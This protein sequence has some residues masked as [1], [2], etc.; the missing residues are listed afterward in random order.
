MVR[1]PE[2]YSCD[3]N[4][5]CFASNSID[6]VIS[7]EIKDHGCTGKV[8]VY[9]FAVK[10]GAPCGTVEIIE[11]Q[12]VDLAKWEAR[13]REKER[14]DLERLRRLESRLIEWT[15]LFGR[16]LCPP[17]ADTYGEGIMD[18]KA[19]VLSMIIHEEDDYS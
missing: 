2:F 9:G 18:A 8:I 5:T 14:K 6:D 7:Q 12:E 19:Q 3:E 10:P 13:A 4:C 16:A 17:R 1:I 15:H 11:E